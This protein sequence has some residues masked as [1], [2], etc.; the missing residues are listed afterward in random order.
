MEIH[1]HIPLSIMTHLHLNLELQVLPQ[2]L[3]KIQLIHENSLKSQMIKVGIHVSVL[4]FPFLKQL[5][6]VP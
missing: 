4:Y 3:Y 6:S 1:I 2:Y 5:K